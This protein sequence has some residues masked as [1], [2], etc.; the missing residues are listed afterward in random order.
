MIPMLIGISLLAFVISINAPVDPIEKLTRSAE[1]EG[2]AGSSSVATKIQKQEWRKK[3]GLDLPIFY[4]S[5][6]NIATTDTLYKIQDRDHQ[7]NLSRL[8][9][10][11]GNWKNVSTYYNHLLKLERKYEK[12]DIKKVIEQDSLLDVNLINEAKNQFG[13]TVK[14]LLSNS[15]SRIISNGFKTLYSL[16]DNNEFLEPLEKQVNKAKESKNYLE[17]H[18]TKW[19]TYI[20]SINWYGFKNQ[21]H[22]WLF[23][24]G[25]DRKGLI[26]GDFGFSYRDQKK[27]EEKIWEKIGISFKFSLISIL[28]AYLVSIPL[29]IFS[30]YRKDSTADRTI[31]VILFVLYAMPSFFVGLLLLFAFAN[32]DTYSFFP[33]GGLKDPT[34]WNP[35]WKWWHLDAI[36]HSSKY[37]ILP[38]ITYTYSSFAFLSRIM[39]IGMID[40]INQ[41][42]IRTARAKGLS[43]KTVILKHALRNSLLPIITVFAA[44]FP[45]AIGGSIIIEVIFSIPGIGVEILNSLTG[46][47]Y[48]MIITIFTISGFL[49]MVGYLVSDLLYAVADPRISYK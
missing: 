37:L 18:K 31:S 47:D 14:N 8:T 1:S 32:P 6:S 17:N 22:T 9:H 15:D 48:P 46:G 43:E 44:I 34:T 27:V 42:Y 29:G 36:K 7:N 41:D 21:Y 4:F 11:T 35:D 10:E 30:A 23:G 38:I 5:I 39:R 2:E 49:T 26:R 16:I 19:K 13:I 25:K 28:I 40:V 45:M 12:I 3:L 20:P 33:A 24:N